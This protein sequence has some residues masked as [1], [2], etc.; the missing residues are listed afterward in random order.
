MAVSRR[1][2]HAEPMSEAAVLIVGAGPVGSIL[3]LEL[4]RHGVPSVLVERSVRPSLHPK[5]DFINGRS[6]ELLRRL[7]LAEEI[8]R[9][10]V[11]PQYSTDFLWT[12]G[13]DRPPVMVWHQPSVDQVRRQYAAVNDGTAPREPY[14]RTQGSLVEQLLRERARDHPLVDLRE[15]WTCADVELGTDGAIATAIDPGGT[16]RAIAARYLVACDGARSTV[17]RGLRIPLDEVGEPAHHRSVYF[18]SRD[19]VLRRHGRAFLTIAARGVTLASRDEDQIWTASMAV[20]PDDPPSADPI[21]LLQERLGVSIAVDEVMSVGLWEGS[22]AV[23]AGFRRGAAFLAGDAAHQFHPAGGH[24]VNTG[25]ADAVDLGWKLAATVNGWGGPALL[26]S[27]EAERRPVAAFNRELCADL[28][29]VAR[30]FARL[31]A[32]GASP[33]HLAGLLEQEAHQIDNAGVHFGHRYGQS[34]V[35]CHEGGEPPPWS[36]RQITASTWPGGRAPSVRL[37][38]GEQLFDEFGD[39][40]TLVDLSDRGIGEPLVK[41]ALDRGIPM[42]HLVLDDAAVRGCWERDLVLVRPDQHVAWRDD[43]PPADWTAVLDRVTG[44]SV[45]AAGLAGEGPGRQSARDHVN[46]GWNLVGGTA[47][48]GRD[49]HP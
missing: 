15:G 44:S 18:R 9:L 38:S 1:E 20:R 7:G 39:G 26:D 12:C 13:F 31:S 22:L 14:Q 10:G 19:P 33:E 47:S 43:L 34:P 30:R 49:H 23:A 6:M 37:A 36:W 21:A 5:M 17:R 40:F 42:T 8:R 35:I 45:G 4:A 24:G 48:S 11:G 25:I 29:E 27:Y 3:A 46:A 41:E 28:V 2:H 16:R 32:A